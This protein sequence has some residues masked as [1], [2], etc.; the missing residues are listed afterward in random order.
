MMKKSP[1]LLKQDRPP[2]SP[3]A[4]PS[5]GFSTTIISS[6]EKSV[7]TGV[8]TDPEVTAFGSGGNTMTC[9]NVID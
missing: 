8:V 6:V 9:D 1:Q 2:M 5:P 3:A 7:A 4:L